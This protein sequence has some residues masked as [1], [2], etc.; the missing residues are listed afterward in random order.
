MY[1]VERPAQLLAAARVRGVKVLLKLPKAGQADAALWRAAHHDVVA[2]SNNLVAAEGR[3]ARDQVDE[4]GLWRLH[5]HTDV[6]RLCCTCSALPPSWHMEPH[7][8][9]GHRAA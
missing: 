4:R 2:Q 5:V 6:S 3:A 8:A 7:Y 1:N 9:S